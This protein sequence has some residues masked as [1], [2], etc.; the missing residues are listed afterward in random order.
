M[1]KPVEPHQAD[2]CNSGCNPCIFDIYQNQLKLYNTYIET[3]DRPSVIVENGISQLHYTTFVVSNTNNICDTLKEIC[4][5]RAS[6]ESTERV[7][8]KP[9]SHFL[10]KY[11]SQHNTCTRAYTPI[12][13]CIN[14]SKDNNFDFF[15][16]VKKYNN[17][18]VSNY[19]FNLMVGDETIWRGPYSSYNIN[20]TYDKMVMICQGTGIAP[21]VSIIDCIL[22]NEDSLTSIILLYCCK[23]A[24][25][26]LFRTELYIFK[27][28][29]NF[30]YKV[31]I[32]NFTE[33][34]I[35]KY[36][37]PVVNKKLCFE[38][39]PVTKIN[40]S[41]QYLLCGSNK[42]MDEYKSHLLSLDIQKDNIVT[43]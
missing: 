26:I 39:L 16:V 18:L 33:D 36:E 34:D 35:L 12:K 27:S 8:W 14:K 3:G 41:I 9:G 25:S 11:F 10:L 40:E 6:P 32:S 24:E 1:N 20:V 43:F 31:F 2:C 7:I 42:F 37:E 23:N 21:F 38:D 19:L 30:S 15:I 17:G 4:F 5:K 29:W 22:D 28:Y 13:L